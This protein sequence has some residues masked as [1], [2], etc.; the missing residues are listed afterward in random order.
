MIIQI[1]GSGCP[2]CKK[3]F[4]LVSEVVHE[5]ESKKNIEI[6]YLT[7]NEG[8]SKIIELGIMSS[9]VV[10]IDNKVINGLSLNKEVIKRRLIEEIEK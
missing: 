3:L 9:P 2:T 8:I 1:L 6:Q 5:L 10:T 4:D 7:G